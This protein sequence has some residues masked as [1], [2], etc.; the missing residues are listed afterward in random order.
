MDVMNLVSQVAG[1]AMSSGQEGGG[2]AAMMNAI[3]GMLGQQSGGMEGLVQA[4]S[5]NGMAEQVQ[6]WV[7]TGENMPI[8]PDQV[9]NVLGGDMIAN[10]AAQVGVS[11]EMASTVVAQVLPLL[12]NQLTPHGTVP[13]GN[14]LQSSISALLGSFLN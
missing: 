9:Q 7:G 12:I 8:S 1:A 13:E 3:A 6:S 10:L 14:D 11:P 5:Q 2:N 4:F